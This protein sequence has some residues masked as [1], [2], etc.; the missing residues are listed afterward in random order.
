MQRLKELDTSWLLAGE[1]LVVN[2]LKKMGKSRN[3]I[4]HLVSA[5]QQM[6]DADFKAKWKDVV[7]SL[8]AIMSTFPKGASQV[9]VETCFSWGLYHD[10][11]VLLSIRKHQHH[12]AL[13]LWCFVLHSHRRSRLPHC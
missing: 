1:T 12:A 5:K 10:R 8:E 9:R 2:A 13:V 7:D 6:T 11:G 4:S 3:G